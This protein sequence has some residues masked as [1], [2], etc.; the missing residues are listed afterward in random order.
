M[1]IATQVSSWTYRFV[2]QFVDKWNDFCVLLYACMKMFELKI[3]LKFI[4]LSMKNAWENSDFYTTSTITVQFHVAPIYSVMIQSF[5]VI[6][7][8]TII[9]SIVSIDIFKVI[10]FLCPSYNSNQII[11]FCGFQ[12]SK[13]NSNHIQIMNVVRVLEW[14]SEWWWPCVPNHWN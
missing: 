13:R 2:Y 9:C 14:M 3:S 7:Q 11:S 12:C 1:T 8:I 10:G 4:S 6:G 5:E